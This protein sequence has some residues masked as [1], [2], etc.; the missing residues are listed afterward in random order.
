MRIYATGRSDLPNQVN[1]SLCFP[2]FLRALL[3]LRVRKITNKM[4]IAA[5]EAIAGCV[6]EEELRETKIVPEIFDTN[7]V[8][9]IK[10]KVAGSL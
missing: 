7:I 10:E 8:P 6:A 3:D 4:K 9:A 1:N 2:G 5:A